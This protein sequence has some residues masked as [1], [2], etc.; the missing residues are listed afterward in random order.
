[1]YKRDLDGLIAANRLPKA[2]LLYGEPFFAEHYARKILPL[3]GARENILSFYFDEYHYESARSFIAQPS[4]FGDVNILYIRSDKK[5]PKKELDSLVA[6]CNKNANSYLLLHFSGED[7]TAK[8]LQKS[9]GKRKGGDFARFFKPNVSEAIALMRQRAEA[10][11]LQI[12]NFALQHLFMLQNEALGLCM[13][14]LEKLSVLGKPITQSDIDTHVYGMGTLTLDQFIVML[15]QKR[16]IRQELSR[17]LENGQGD[18]IRIVN[19]ITNYITQLMLFHIYIKV[20]GRYDA[21]EIVGYPLP[22]QLVK[23]RA[24]MS[25]RFRLS[26]FRQLLTHLLQTEHTLKY[27]QHIDKNSYLIS[28]LIKLQT[29][30]Q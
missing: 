3:W 2:L 19:A 10:L 9:F 13:Q 21:G 17:L 22:P 1:M 12:E 28:S 24:A 8:E 20:H 4:L 23:E 18:E 30:L 5:I 11:G 6:L 27:A 7:R 14:E 16:D 15:L 26:T 29:Y 25:I